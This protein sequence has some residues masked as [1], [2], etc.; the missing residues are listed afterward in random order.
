MPKVNLTQGHVAID[1]PSEEAT[2]IHSLKRAH[3]PDQTDER[4][5]LLHC[6]DDLA[7]PPTYREYHS[8][9]PFFM[10]FRGPT[11]LEDRRHKTIV[12]PTD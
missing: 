2:P 11:A 3:A 5:L 9:W 1:A 8:L 4:P 12:C 7:A 10:K 6:P